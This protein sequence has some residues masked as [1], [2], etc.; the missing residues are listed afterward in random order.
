MCSSIG[1]QKSVI[2]KLSEWYRALRAHNPNKKSRKK[3]RAP[4]TTGLEKGEVRKK[5]FLFQ[6]Q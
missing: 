4:F 1:L 2:E 5:D 3:N 6:N